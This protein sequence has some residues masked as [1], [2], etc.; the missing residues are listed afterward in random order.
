MSLVVGSTRVDREVC[1]APLSPPAESDMVDV[2]GAPVIPGGNVASCAGLSWGL[3]TV[4]LGPPSA[5]SR[6]RPY[7]DDPGVDGDKGSPA[8][9]RGRLRPSDV[10]ELECASCELDPLPSR[11]VRWPGERDEPE[12][13]VDEP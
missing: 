10:M 2:D 5:D 9:R 12:L 6:A 11:G 4:L 7:A 8:S 3:V 1:D 13:Y